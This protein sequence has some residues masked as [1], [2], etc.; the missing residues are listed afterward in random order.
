MSELDIILN[1]RPKIQ[2]LI[3][4]NQNENKK[5]VDALPAVKPKIVAKKKTSKQAKKSTKNLFE[6]FIFE[7]PPPEALLLDEPVIK[8]TDSFKQDDEFWKFYK[9]NT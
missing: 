8:K 2:A 6:D 7:D 4:Q 5:P 3:R 9:Q 1:S